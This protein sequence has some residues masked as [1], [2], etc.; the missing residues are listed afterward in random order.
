MAQPLMM[1]DKIGKSD[2]KCVM[3]NVSNGHALHDHV[4]NLFQQLFQG[5][6]SWLIKDLCGSCAFIFFSYHYNIFLQKYSIL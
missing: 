1:N 2:E 3:S 6:Y 5:C 4:E